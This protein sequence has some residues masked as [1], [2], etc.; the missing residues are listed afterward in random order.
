MGGRGREK[1]FLVVARR[2]VAHP[3]PIS[4]SHERKRERLRRVS[5]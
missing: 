1:F 4:L 2:R 5:F 3:Y